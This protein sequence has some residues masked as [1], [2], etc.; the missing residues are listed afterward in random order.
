MEETLRPDELQELIDRGR[1]I[2]VVTRFHRAIDSNTWTLMRDE[3]LAPDVV[4]EWSATNASGP[5]ADGAAGR[6]DVIAW[7]SSAMVGSEVRHFTTS[8]LVDIEGDHAHS[9]SYMVVVDKNSLT[10]LANGL[11]TVDHVRL[12]EGWRM[13][14][15]SIDERIPD[16]MVEGMQTLLRDGAGEAMTHHAAVADERD[17][18]AQAGRAR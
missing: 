11:V 2:D 18:T 7:L 3:V 5:M 8:H 17:E 10:V 13:Q 14:R 4:W 15:C 6:E 16:T 1:I 9:E 12:P